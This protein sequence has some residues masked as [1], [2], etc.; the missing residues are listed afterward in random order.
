MKSFID[1]LVILLLF[2]LFGL[3]HS[4]LASKKVKHNIR[5]KAG[6]KIAFYRLFYNL[7]SIITIIIFYEISPKPDILIYDLPN[8]YD[9][10]IFVLQFMSLIGFIWCAVLIDGMEFIGINQIKRYFKNEYDETELDEHQTLIMKGPFK[11]SRHPIYLFSI[12]FLWLRPVMDL[13][14][15][16]FIIC[17]TIYF[18]IG[19]YL[20][21]NRLIKV[22]GTRYENYRAEVPRFIPYRIFSKSSM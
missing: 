3:V 18:I 9:I 8:P 11:Y 20:E 21:E 4:V 5:L 15:L 14:Y 1:V 6:K 10:I 13:F 2:C 22:F 16:I 19:S 17:T 12:L 7:T